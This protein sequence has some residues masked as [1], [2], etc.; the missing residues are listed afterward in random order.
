MNSSSDLGGSR[1]WRRFGRYLL[2]E[3]LGAGG[4]GVVYRAH[5]DK[6]GR[7]V[8]LKFLPAGTLVDAA[9]RR[10]FR[11]EAL[12]LSKL[13]H[14]NIETVY[15][16]DSLEGDDFLVIEYVP[17]VS[18]DAKLAAGPLGAD[19]VVALGAQLARGLAAAHERGVVHRDLK[20]GNL[21]LTPDGQLKILDFGLAKIARAADGLT[22]G[23]ATL[24]L[25]E[26]NQAVLAGTIPYMSPEQLRGEAVDSRSD[27]FAAGAVL[28]EMAT[29]VRPFP[30]LQPAALIDAILNR[31]PPQPRSLRPD[32]PAALQDIILA[33]LVKDPA[34]R[35]P[36]AR[37]LYQ[38]L[39]ALTASGA[40][41]PAPR[42]QRRRRLVAFLGAVALLAVL[43]GLREIGAFRA[44]RASPPVSLHH[45]LA[46]LPLLNLSGDP[47][48]EFFADGMT[49]EV[50]AELGKIASLRV[51][52]RTSMMQYKNT[53]VPLSRLARELKVDTV[54]EAS[55]Q[56]VEGRIRVRARLVDAAA[57][58]QIWSDAYE[59]EAKEVLALQ[60]DVARAVATAIHVELTPAD[61]SRLATSRSIDPQAHEAYLRGRSHLGR[62]TQVDFQRALACFEQAIGIDPTWAGAYVGLA[63][64]YYQASTLFLP[65]E[66]AMPRARAAALRALDL[67]PS[68]AGA[69]LALG[70]V[71]TFYDW[72]WKS[73]PI[74]LARAVELAPGNAGAHEAYGYYLTI[75][76][77]F[78]AALEHL[79]Q[80]CEIDPLSLHL[81][82]Y[83]LFPLYE[84]RRYDEAIERALAVLASHP[85]AWNARLVLGQ[86]YLQMKE[87]DKAIDAFQRASQ[88][89]N[90][91]YVQVLLGSAYA[92][93]GKQTEAREV[94]AHLEQNRI[95]MHAHAYAV[96]LLYMELGET[97]AA[98]EWLETS[99]AQRSEEVLMIKADP[100][101]DPLRPDP[102]FQD[103]M[104]RVGFSMP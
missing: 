9:E 85:E 47:D 57:D 10:I 33:A 24:T 30:Q 63:E 25:A 50:I 81:R 56:L 17:G 83:A 96:A 71:K 46:V 39:E 31:E 22:L 38:R 78:D 37:V 65:P 18:L 82:V 64:S 36:S 55:V 95:E 53:K 67:E 16:F 21:R 41:H 87:Y 27:L 58:R 26:T 92:A 7:D 68:S 51:I 48:L 61:E 90:H 20:P 76:C 15:D 66:E 34:Q 14:P 3:R 73:G 54:L 42:P 84:G 13:N 80:A 59:R 45:S 40:G 44:R 104:R 101:L 94:L 88:S 89:E 100:Q 93:A 72:D 6:L 1:L 74:E 52:S 11:Q 91:P 69:R 32:I 103:L 62:E 97:D 49:E 98:F 19:E 102:R 23:A 99:F 35:L 60:N 43:L 77:E 8:A 75:A 12:V 4:M 5:D 28:Y 86:A 70:V 79:R 29:G 2:L